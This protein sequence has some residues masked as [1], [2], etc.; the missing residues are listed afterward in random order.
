MTGAGLD[1]NKIEQF[2]RRR[3]QLADPRVGPELKDRR[4]GFE[5]ELVLSRIRRGGTILDLGCGQGTLTGE[6]LGVADRVIAVDKFPEFFKLL[7][8]DPKLTATASDVMTYDPVDAVPFSGVLLFGVANYLTPAEQDVL[9]GRI[10]SWLEPGGVLIVKHACGVEAEVVVDTHSEALG[11]WY[12]ARYPFV[13][14]ERGI[15]VRHFRAVDVVD[16]YP[17]E[18]NPWQNTHFY[19]FVARI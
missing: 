10:A 12:H 2:W 14:D 17:P 11:E 16:V 6:L 3:T 8:S 7:P 13:E 4:Y 9:Y 18:L 5:R 1:K 15:L 19:A